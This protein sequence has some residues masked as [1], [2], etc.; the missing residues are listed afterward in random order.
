MT[1]NRRKYDDISTRDIAVTNAA[2]IDGIENNVSEIKSDVKSLKKYQWITFGVLL[3]CTCLM[4][5]PQLIKILQPSGQA[6]AGEAI[7]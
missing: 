4:N 3:A 7:K 5:Y 6:Y 2:R 1:P